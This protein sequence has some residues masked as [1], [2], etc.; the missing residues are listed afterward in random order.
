MEISPKFEFDQ[1]PEILK[2]LYKRI[3]KSKDPKKI[4]FY[5]KQL[6]DYL[7]EYA[8]NNIEKDE[9]WK[10]EISFLVNMSLGILI[11]KTINEELFPVFFMFRTI[12]LFFYIRDIPNFFIVHNIHIKA[13]KN[14]TLLNNS[15][16]DWLELEN[17]LYG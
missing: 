16:A 3:W 4:T 2:F 5:S 13:I 9:N 12:D 17:R 8:A 7:H 14:R 6:S 15:A 11:A 10:K 1:Y